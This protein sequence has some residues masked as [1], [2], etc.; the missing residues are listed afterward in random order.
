MFPEG[1]C[2]AV[3]GSAHGDAVAAR[4]DRAAADQP[5]LRRVDVPAGR[6][7]LHRQSDGQTDGQARRGLSAQAG[8]RSGGAGQAD[9]PLRGRLQ[10][11]RLPQ[12]VSVDLQPGQRRAGDRAHRQ[13]HRLG[14]RDRRRWP[15]RGR[16]ADPGDRVQ[17]AGH[18]QRTDLPGDRAER[19]VP[20]V[21]LGR[22]PVAGLR[23]RQHSG[24]P[25]LLHRVRPVRLRRL[26]VL[27]AHRGP[28]PPHRPVPRCGASPAGHPRRGAPGSQRPLLRRDD[29]QAAPADLLAGQ[30]PERPTATTS[31]RTA[32]YRCGRRRRWRR[33]GA[34]VAFRSRTTS[35]SADP[36]DRAQSARRKPSAR[37]PC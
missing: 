30:L 14:R 22:E 27:R 29:A 2:P 9:A 12:H 3:A 32:T 19:T 31:T 20:G 37:R 4:Q 23:G 1:R 5:D 25:E 16:R 21:I 6:A 26:V 28:D 7:V 34:A 10:A 33:T 35:S 8:R 15:A 17:G 36:T 18:R 13:D 11:S 24:L